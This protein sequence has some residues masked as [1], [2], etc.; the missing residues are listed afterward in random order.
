MLEKK[1]NYHGD[2]ESTEIHGGDSVYL[3]DLRAS[4]VSF[5]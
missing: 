3:R 4:V 2:T 5:Y 1:I